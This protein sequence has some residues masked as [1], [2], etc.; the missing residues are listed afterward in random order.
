MQGFKHYSFDLWMTLIRSNPVFKGE[1]ASFFHRNYNPRKKSLEE[2]TAIFRQVDVMCNAINE[3]T[4]GNIDAEEM[5]GMVLSAMTDY[6]AHLPDFDLHE[7]YAEVEV[8][9]LNNLPM[10][11]CSS[12]KRVLDQ[13]AQTGKSKI[14]LLSNTAFI[15]GS[16]LRKVM[17]QLQLAFYFDFQIYSDEL[18]LSKPNPAL[19]G[20]FRQTVSEH[21]K[22]NDP[23]LQ[24]IIH[25]GDNYRA[26]VLGAKTLGIEGLLINSN[27]SCI[28]T[29]LN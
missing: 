20:H 24:E 16:T 6:E 23:D 5:Y 9:L 12:T 18:G 15:K 1:R 22:D 25:I 13:L 28:S 4:G 19:F 14:S 27:N 26:D 7:I 11:F 29:L 3:R 21:W 8:L 17:D 10:L 2:V